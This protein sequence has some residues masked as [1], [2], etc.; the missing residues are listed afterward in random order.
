VNE[1]LARELFQKAEA[2]FHNGI[3][4]RFPHNALYD[5]NLADPADFEDQE[6]W[7]RN[8]MNNTQHVL[9]KILTKHD[10]APGACSHIRGQ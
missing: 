4:R 9:L 2:D 8:K 6:R 1:R 7:E 5:K 10:I 3:K